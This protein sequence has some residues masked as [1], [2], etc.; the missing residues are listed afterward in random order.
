MEK[1][2]QEYFLK[3]SFTR[4]YYFGT[5]PKF[6]IHISNNNTVYLAVLRNSFVQNSSVVESN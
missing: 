6:T 2:F 4:I 1:Y 3:V 5:N